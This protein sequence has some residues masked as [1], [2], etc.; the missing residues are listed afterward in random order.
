[1]TPLVHQNEAFIDID[2]VYET[3]QERLRKKYRISEKSSPF[4]RAV[5]NRALRHTYHQDLQDSILMEARRLQKFLNEQYHRYNR[6]VFVFASAGKHEGVASVVLN[7]A[8]AFELSTEH[9]VLFIDG[10]LKTPGFSRFL[11]NIGLGRGLLDMLSENIETKDVLHKLV[12]SEV[13]FMSHG[14][15]RK[16]LQGIVTRRRLRR[17]LDTVKGLFDMIIIASP[18]LELYPDGYLWGELSDGMIL[19]IHAYETSLKTVKK[20]KQRAHRYNVALLGTILNRRQ[21]SIPRF[22]YEWL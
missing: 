12:S 11:G 15:K 14:R 17:L 3:A 2:Y 5:A 9:S 4:L 10:N 21:Y 1:M 19:V 18:P 22:F 20:I 16:Q 8:R 7:L 13:Y 6:R